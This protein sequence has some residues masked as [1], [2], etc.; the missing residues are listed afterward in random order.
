MHAIEIKNGE[1][2]FAYNGNNGN[3]WHGL[4]TRVEGYSTVNDM[5]V[6]AIAN[7]SVEKQPLYVQAPNG[8]DLVEVPNKVATV[9]VEHTLNAD[10]VATEYAPLGVVGKDY[11]VE[12]NLDA[13]LWAV[14]LVGASGGD[15]VI[16]TM[17]V[18][19][20][21]REFF[22]GVDLGTLVLDP[23][24]IGDVIKRYLVVRN[25]HDGTSSLCAF[26]TMTR[27]VCN[28]TLTAA[29]GGAKRSSQIHNVRHTSGKDNRKAEA[30]QAMGIAQAISEKFIES[31]GAMMEISGG[32]DRLDQV[33]NTLWEKPEASASDRTRTIWGNRRSKIHRLYD[34]DTNAGRFGDSGW[35]VWNAVGE[36]LDHSRKN[37][38]KQAIASLDPM[39]EDAR[40]KDKAFERVLS[41]A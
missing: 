12:Q 30:V 18:L 41:F 3:T 5:L 14:D 29:W 25:R 27:V 22:V 37:A 7:W 1:H 33:I 19:H 36:Y 20:D 24:G 31:A 35:T 17:G 39:S 4:G 15:A 11:A 13:A 10:G 32:H 6:A 40:L 38:T 21:G 34:A 26:P 2:R 23:D 9:R 8:V 16:D 28:N